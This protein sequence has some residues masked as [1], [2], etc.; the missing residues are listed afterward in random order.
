MPT[1]DD[2]YI[3]C[4]ELDNIPKLNK[5]NWLNEIDLLTKEFSL[6]AKILQVGC[7]DGT[8]IQALLKAR[9]DLIITGLDIED[10]MVNTCKKNFEMLGLKANFILGDITKP[11]EVSDF[12]YVICLNN[13][14]G[15]IDDQQ[16]AIENMKKL[17]KI[18]IISVYGEKFDDELGKEYFKIINLEVE[19]IENNVFFMKDFVNVKRYIHE[20]VNK[21]GGEIIETPL[22]Y[23]V[24]IKS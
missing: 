24:I 4:D 8:R 16:K 20:E 22:G 9:P 12:D 3:Q 14:L 23:F 13:T 15:Y 19:K 1:A 10:S 7:M 18:V 2:V 21:W 11:I 5:D 6:N 17:G